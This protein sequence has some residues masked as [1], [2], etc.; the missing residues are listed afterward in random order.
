MSRRS[1][2]ILRSCLCA[3]RS[4]KIFSKNHL[5]CKKHK[6]SLSRMMILQ[7]NSAAHCR[8]MARPNRILVR[9]ILLPPD[10]RWRIISSATFRRPKSN[11]PGSS[12][13]LIWQSRHTPARSIWLRSCAISESSRCLSWSTMVKYQRTLLPLPPQHIYS[14]KSATVL[15]ISI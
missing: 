9:Q 14:T 4:F 12:S 6:V 7:R 11:R 10:A 13:K 5:D 2:K 1:S 3:I 15:F 8:C